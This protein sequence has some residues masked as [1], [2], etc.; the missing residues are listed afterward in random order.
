MK[1][2]TIKSRLVLLSILACV[3]MLIMATIQITTTQKLESLGHARLLVSKITT[4]MLMLR[5]NEKDFLARKDLKYREKFITNAQLMK[6]TIAE[7]QQTL[8]KNTID[9]S[10]STDLA[11]ITGEYTQKFLAII[12]LQSKIGLNPKDGLYGSLRTAVHE[13]EERINTQN[14]NSLTK[15][16]LML[17]RR[18][19][20]FMLRMDLT[21]VEKF[22]RDMAIFEA[23][24]ENSN[25]SDTVKQDIADTM[26]QYSK[27]FHRLIAMEQKKG[28]NSKLGILGD[29]RNTIHKSEEI[30]TTLSDVT[31]DTIEKSISHQHLLSVVLTILITLAILSMIAFIAFSIIK[32]IEYLSQKM[33][34]A[35]KNH[36][37]SVRTNLQG[38]DE[39]SFAAQIFDKMMNEFSQLM[40]QVLTSAEQLN[41]V[42][43][44][45]A[46]VTREGK[47]SALRQ[48]TETAQVA[49]AMNQMTTTV[50]E[51]SNSASRA[52][53]LSNTA[54]QEVDRSKNVVDENMKSIQALAHEV[55]NTTDTISTLSKDS[56]NI[57]DVLNVI[58][59][60]AEQTNLLA[61]NAAIEAA[62]AGEQG[63]GFA[64][65]A[66]EVRS[67]AQRSQQSTQEIQA[68]VE[69][70]QQSSERAVAAM[71]DGQHKATESVGKAQSVS[72]SLDKISTAVASINDMN[73][74][75]ASAAE[76]QS[77]VSAEVN[78]N[79]VNINEISNETATNT[80]EVNITCE[81]L[82]CLSDELRNLVSHFKL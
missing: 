49:T 16:M 42:S 71:E 33:A 29:M 10:Q 23:S 21:Y 4:E 50:Q 54:N 14:D 61:L 67:L 27:N 69:R 66:D 2:L 9:T 1:S 79:V 43:E 15:E 31:R 52:A 41:T 20:D 73:M 81:S 76:E 28:L 8:E 38:N 18:E 70:L 35:C 60:I 74:Q 34:F 53:D 68:I 59:G 26:K 11:N 37:L 36:D 47:D 24:L 39:I 7:L 12:D 25:H 13:A 30:L 56:E 55:Q 80:T 64:V 51:V 32:P 19:K 58:K 45:L 75:I 46:T 40:N 22:D 78:R 82:A 6:T 77:A 44:K 62:R 5:R 48:D 72:E 63:R 65:V 3:G 57:G 17:R